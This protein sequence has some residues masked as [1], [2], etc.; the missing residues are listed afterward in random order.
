ATAPDF[1]AVVKALSGKASFWHIAFGGALISFVGYGSAQFL[2]SHLV[3]NYDIGATLQEEIANAAY[4]L[5]LVACG[6][7]SLGPF[8]GGFLSDRLGAR[9]PHVNSWLPA[10]GVA[11]A[12]PI[13]A[14]SFFQPGFNV[15]LTTLLIAPVFH[16]LYLGPMFAVTQGSAEPRM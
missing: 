16:Y 4:T 14:I 7:R 2:G 13:Y 1:G 15:A 3:R 9:H 6:S 10:L 5:G 11:V 8:L 12:V